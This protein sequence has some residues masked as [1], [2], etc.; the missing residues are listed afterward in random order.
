MY[1][2]SDD[3]LLNFEPYKMVASNIT[4]GGT[5]LFRPHAIEGWESLD[6]PIP[7]RF[8][9]GHFFFTIGKHC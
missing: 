9:S 8:V 5:I 3:R 1:Q 7:A 2:P 6:S 4:P